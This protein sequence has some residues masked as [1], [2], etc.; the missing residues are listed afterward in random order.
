[1]LEVN[2]NKSYYIYL[3]RA[4]QQGC[5]GVVVITLVLHTKGPQ[6]D[7]GQQHNEFYFQVHIFLALVHIFI[8]I[9]NEKVPFAT[10]LIL[11]FEIYYTTF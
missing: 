9:I 5:C 7:P 6:F 2:W 1:M 10:L 8:I 11:H 3:L 4:Y